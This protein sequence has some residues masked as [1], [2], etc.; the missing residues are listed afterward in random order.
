ML[1]L[2]MN[3]QQSETYTVR[4][5]RYSTT[6]TR[7]FFHYVCIPVWASCLCP[8]IIRGFRVHNYSNVFQNFHFS[9]SKCCA[10]LYV[11]RGFYT[12]TTIVSSVRSSSVAS[13][14]RKQ[15][16]LPEN[17]CRGNCTKTGPKNCSVVF[18]E[19]ELLSIHQ[20]SGE[21]GYTLQLFCPVF[22]KL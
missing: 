5:F 1:P 12:L 6:L 10:S 17:I 15:T 19:C 7:I 9:L 11:R 4:A 8:A 16:V 20:S 14:L 18:S 21:K 22:Q 3:M 13:S 2:D